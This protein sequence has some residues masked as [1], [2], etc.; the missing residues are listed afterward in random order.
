MAKGKTQAMTKW[1]EKLA[2]Q[3]KLATKTLEG[4]GGGGNF[5]STRGG[6][7][8]YRGGKVPGGKM[9]V[10]VLD[11]ILENDW[12]ENKFDADN[13]EVPACFAYARHKDDLRPHEKSLKPQHEQ[14]EGCPKN[15]FGTAD[16]GKGKAC[17]NRVRLALITE[18]DLDDVAK[19]EL[20]FLKVP[21]TSVKAWVGYVNQIQSVEKRPPLGVVTE[22]VVE[23]DP[24][25]QVKVSFNYIEP[26]ADDKM[27][28]LFAK[29]ETTQKKIV[30]PYVAIAKAPAAARGKGGKGKGAA[31]GRKF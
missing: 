14:C 2:E 20:A 27:E 28:A 17:Q 12:F 18:G 1:D 23:P 11:F 31:A 25:N 21:V 9:R 16:T 6:I 15:E 19:A 3:A 7:L 13:M 26:V 8:T 30:E 5:L 29:L 10:V 22:I 24:Q 4:V